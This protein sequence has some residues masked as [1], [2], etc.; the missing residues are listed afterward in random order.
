[1]TALLE[2]SKVTK[3]VGSAIAVHD[4]DLTVAIGECVAVVGPNG[5]GCS[6]LLRLMA[7][8]IA[9]SAGSITINGIDAVTHVHSVRR[10]L[11]Y[12]SETLLEAPAMLTSEYLDFVRKARPGQPARAGRET[13][14]TGDIL[15]RGALPGRSAR[16]QPVGGTP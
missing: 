16:G 2:L 11:A 8:V 10:S 4:I 1:M 9:P 7:T 3:R 13:P 5:S 15:R 14:G 6:T 12:A